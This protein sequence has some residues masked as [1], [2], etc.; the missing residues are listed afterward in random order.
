MAVEYGMS[1]IEELKGVLERRRN[2]LEIFGTYK[3]TYDNFIQEL[4]LAYEGADEDTAASA[5]YLASYVMD[6][7]KDRKERLTPMDES[8]RIRIVLENLLVARD[9]YPVDLP[10]LIH[11]YQLIYDWAAKIEKEMVKQGRLHPNINVVIVNLVDIFAVPLFNFMKDINKKMDLRWA[12]A[13]LQGAMVKE[14]SPLVFEDIKNSFPLTEMKVENFFIAGEY[15]IRPFVEEY[16]KTKGDRSKLELFGDI[17][18]KPFELAAS[19]FYNNQTHELFMNSAFTARFRNKDDENLNQ[20]LKE[21]INLNH[22]L[23]RKSDYKFLFAKFNIRIQSNGQFY[24]RRLFLHNI[25]GKQLGAYTFLLISA[26]NINMKVLDSYVK[27]RF[28]DIRGLKEFDTFTNTEK[29]ARLEYW[30]ETYINTLQEE[31]DFLSEIDTKRAQ[32]F[33]PLAI[34]KQEKNES[35]VEL[36]SSIP[37]ESRKLVR[38]IDGIEKQDVKILDKLK[39]LINFSR[40]ITI[41]SLSILRLLLINFQEDEKEISI[42]FFPEEILFQNEKEESDNIIIRSLTDDSRIVSI[43]ARNESGIRSTGL[44]KQR[45]LNS[46]INQL[47]TELR[48]K[49][50]ETAVKIRMEDT[51]LFN[52]YKLV[53]LEAGKFHFK[54]KVS[55]S[56]DSLDA[57]SNIEEELTK[58]KKK[59]EERVKELKREEEKKLLELRRI[60]YNDIISTSLSERLSKFLGMHVLEYFY[61]NLESNKIERLLNGISYEIDEWEEGKDKVFTTEISDIVACMLTELEPKFK[62]E[63][64]DI[65]GGYFNKIKDRIDMMTADELLEKM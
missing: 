51:G 59:E 8:E 32:K 54:G 52:S 63:V 39:Q 21:G 12:M 57:T 45:Q 2:V 16:M 31:Y 61:S 56:V 53:N 58:A 17:G 19:S 18:E 35:Q 22:T 3:S 47:L 9:Y 34:G 1:L 38:R 46:K 7:V 30:N 10:S 14:V 4:K 62:E 64:L 40:P 49:S 24:D 50:L 27:S 28:T 60:Y 37:E 11:I 5:I 25:E 41:S 20:A 42:Q 29:D 15:V 13:E 55:Q 6:T 33:L 23:L 43:I 65:L 48:V 44:L 36:I 26:E